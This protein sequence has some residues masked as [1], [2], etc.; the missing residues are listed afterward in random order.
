HLGGPQGNPLGRDA[1]QGNPRISPGS[2]LAPD[3]TAGGTFST[4]GA[5][6]PRFQGFQGSGKSLNP[7]FPRVLSKQGLSVRG[8]ISAGPSTRCGVCA[9]GRCGGEYG[10]GRIPRSSPG[11]KR[12]F[13]GG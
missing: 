10:P 6:G 4:V 9:S 2:A 7:P 13:R 12:P 3:P 11:S 1:G 5:Q 8:I